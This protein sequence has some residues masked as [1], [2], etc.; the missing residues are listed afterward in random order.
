M[1]CKVFILSLLLVNCSKIQND[2]NINDDKISSEDR[3]EKGFDLESGEEKLF[4]AKEDIVCNEDIDCA[5]SKG[6]TASCIQGVCVTDGPGCLYD[7]D[8]FDSNPCVVH[9]CEEGM[10]KPYS[11]HNQS[12]CIDPETGLGGIC[13]GTTCVVLRETFAENI[14]SVCDVKSES[15]SA[16]ECVFSSNDCM[17][18]VFKKN[19]FEHLPNGTSCENILGA[20]GTCQ[21]GYC[22][23]DD[24]IESK[25]DIRCSY[26]N[27]YDDW[28]NIIHRQKNCRNKK[29]IKF[30]IS[31]EK[32]RSAASKIKTSIMK[33]LRY[34]VHV[35]IVQSYNGGYNII[36][37]NTHK[38]DK[39]R[40]MIDPSLIAWNIATFTKRTNWRSANLQV[41]IRPRHDGW[42]MTTSGSRK[43]VKKGQEGAGWLGR[44]GVINVK[45][46]RI[47][48]E[49]NFKYI[50]KGY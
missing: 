6:V 26:Q 1:K 44:Y 42:H 41:W 4:C 47:W 50:E 13:A 49:K 35:G 18:F 33:N 11:E 21:S 45:Q 22:K 37:T 2:Q 28:G 46:F 12:E 15:F 40:G 25:P 27:Y 5:L 31:D 29:K 3:S 39:V 9:T 43:A 14:D 7:S 16:D 17:K 10:C 30:K 24:R 38:K 23:Y 34:D 8:C 32:I 36:I 48:L 19:S 20:P